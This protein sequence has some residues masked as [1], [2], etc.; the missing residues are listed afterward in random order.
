MLPIAEGAVKVTHAA[1]VSVSRDIDKEWAD[2]CAQH[3]KFVWKQALHYSNK[4]GMDEKDLA[5]E[6]FIG[7]RV[8]VEHFDEEKNVKFLTYAGYW[9]MQR[10]LCYIRKHKFNVRIPRQR[11]YD[12]TVVKH[13][14]LSLNHLIGDG[15]DI[16]AIHELAGDVNPFVGIEAEE[17]KLER[18]AAIDNVLSTMQESDRKLLLDFA[19]GYTL[20]Q[21]ADPIGITREAVRLRLAKLFAKMRKELKKQGI[22]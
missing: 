2:M 17:Y 18:L 6:G 21:L 4:Y 10:I 20:Q 13:L 5:Q 9:V 16:E 19:I 11:Y 14:E 3:G 1:F 8:A 15:G 22:T 12:K 7:L